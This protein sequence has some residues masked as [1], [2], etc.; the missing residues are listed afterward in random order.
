MFA[1]CALLLLSLL[2]KSHDIDEKK[3]DDLRRIDP[4]VPLLL[5]C[6]KLKYNKV[7]YQDNL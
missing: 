1:E 2:L 3:A 7:R 4:F 5:R 6:L